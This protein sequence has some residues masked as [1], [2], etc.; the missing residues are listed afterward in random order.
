MSA[1][2]AEQWISNPLGKGLDQIGIDRPELNI[3]GYKT[4]LTALTNPLGALGQGLNLAKNYEEKRLTAKAIK[5]E[6]KKYQE[7]L[8]A[9]EKFKQQEGTLLSG[10]SELFVPQFKSGKSGKLA[11]Q[12]EA[13]A[14]IFNARKQESL[15]RRT[16]PGVAQT[17]MS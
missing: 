15:Q 1:K 8:A 9:F 5:E 6:E 3:G 7:D 2:G 14:Q 17:R 12:T 10:Q 16:T 13:L 4:D 11:Q